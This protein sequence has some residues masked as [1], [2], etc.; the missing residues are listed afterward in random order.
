MKTN[1]VAQV[2]GLLV[3][4]L[5]AGAFGIEVPLEAGE[6][7]NAPVVLGSDGQALPFAS[8]QDLLDYLRTAQ[9][10]SF[11]TLSHGITK[12]EKILLEQ[13]GIAAQVVFHD[14]DS[15]EQ[16]TKRLPNGNVVLY[17]KDS[18]RSQIAA[19]ELSRMLGMEN[20]PPTVERRFKSARGS[21][22]LWIENAMTE[23]DRVE[24]G[25]KPPD[26]IQW[27]RRYADMRVFDNL[28]NNIDRNQGNLLVD[29]SWNLWMIDHTRS[30]GR[31]RTLPRPELIS[32]CS[33]RLWNRRVELD[34]DEVH[35][36]VSPYLKK[37]E[38]RSI[39]FRREKLIEHLE[40]EIASKGE[41]WVIFDYGA[42]DP[43]V[44][45]RQSSAISESDQ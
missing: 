16:R 19:Y 15:N 12:A 14:V 26:H 21:A 29:A 7:T 9:G 20:V 18:Y 27:G 6:G 10:L 33:R 40:E 13:D 24:K 23:L 2:V 32:R 30:F 43:G 39:F 31:D 4:S 11:K 44:E 5:L 1:V 34:E 22:Q 42:P 17:V 38:L 45:V 3:F 37:T 35:A 8:E 28:I 41:K 36:R 25:L